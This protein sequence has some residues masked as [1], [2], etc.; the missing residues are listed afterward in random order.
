MQS[1]AD[2]GCYKHAHS[3]NQL[4]GHGFMILHTNK[5]SISSKKSSI[6]QPGCLLLTFLVSETDTSTLEG[7]ELSL[8]DRMKVS[9]QPEPSR[10]L[11]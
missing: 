4:C 11:G 9:T 3:N 10:G 6:S 2:G 5:E 7:L 1:R 8:G